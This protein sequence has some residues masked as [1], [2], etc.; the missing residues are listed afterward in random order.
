MIFVPEAAV[1][2]SVKG[3]TRVGSPPKPHTPNLPTSSLERAPQITDTASS[4]IWVE[5]GVSVRRGSYVESNY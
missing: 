4:D 2:G 5:E 3:T 1:K